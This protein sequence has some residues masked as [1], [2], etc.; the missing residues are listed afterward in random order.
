M[1]RYFGI[2]ITLLLFSACNAQEKI[3]KNETAMKEYKIQKTEEEWKE[4]L[5][6]EEYRI[7][8]EKGTEYPFTGE[9]NDHYKEGVYSCAA[10]DFE[11]FDSSQKFK[12]HCGWPS[13]DSELG[14]DRVERVA[15]N[16]LGMKRVEILCGNC[17]G[18]LGHIF[19]DGPTETGMRYCVNS[20]SL[21][22]TPTNKE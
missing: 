18:H 11:L 12:S 20:V 22:F 6:E 14:G 4:I 5:T 15:D 8:R 19:D 17:G 10:C 21:K 9:Y 16:S 7:L 3:D 13:F 2:L 1:K